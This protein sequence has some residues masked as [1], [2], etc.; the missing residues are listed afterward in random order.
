M[1]VSRTAVDVSDLPT[2]TFGH[3]DLMWWGTIGFMAIEGTTFFVC[4]VSYF[5]L[6]LNF[7]TWPPEHTLRPDLR[8]PT[9]QAALM[10][11][12]NIP[13]YLSD[14][15]ARRADLAALRRW[16]VVL[17]IVGV[18][19]LILRWQEFLALNVRWDSNAY[20]SITWLTLGFHGLVL[21]FQAVETIVF[22]LFLFG[23]RILERHF[24]DATDAATYWY[25]MT[26]SWIILYAIVFLSPRLM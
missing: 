1:T 17:S 20:G 3:R 25:F 24:S 26:G 5:Y 23:D 6:R 4:V 12:S 13:N 14:R 2:T 7:A 22:T 21:V 8:W 9:V 19:F 15:A 18:L 11:I 10:L 16:M